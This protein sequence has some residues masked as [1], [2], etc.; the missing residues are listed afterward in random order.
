MPRLRRSRWARPSRTS[1]LASSSD[2]GLFARKTQTPRSFCNGAFA[3]SGPQ[4][5]AV[6]FDCE[7]ECIA[8]LEAQL[9][10]DH[11]GNDDATRSVDCNRAFHD[12][13]LKMVFSQRQMV[14]TGLQPS[15]LRGTFSGWSLDPAWTVTR[16]LDGYNGPGFRPNQQANEHCSE[17]A[18]CIFDNSKNYLS[19][20]LFA[21]VSLPPHVMYSLLTRLPPSARFT[22][23]CGLIP[24]ARR[25]EAQSATRPCG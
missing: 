20:R 10:A 23:Y 3:C 19:R 8:G 18:A 17:Q 16:Q 12:D 25:D 21:V 6:T 14:I 7:G 13:H 4:G 22:K 11:L 5:H 9:I 2:S 24:T 15:S 1:R